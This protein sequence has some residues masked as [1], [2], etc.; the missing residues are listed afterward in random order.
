MRQLLDLERRKFLERS[1]PTSVERIVRLTELGRLHALGGRDP[2]ACWARPWDRRWR[3][4][5]FDVPTTRNSARSRLRR[6][7]R[8]RHF[9]YLQ[10]SVWISPDPLTEEREILADAS[11]DVES[12]I[13]M[14][15]HPCAGEFD[16]QI[17]AGDW[18][19]VRINREYNWTRP[20]AVGSPKASPHWCGSRPA[21]AIPPRSYRAP[22][23]PDHP[24]GSANW[25]FRNRRA[26]SA[27]AAPSS[28]TPCRRGQSTTTQKIPRKTPLARHRPL[29]LAPPDY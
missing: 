12:L 28:I 11:T 1:P 15:A 6:Y 25:H 21:N 26:T 19:F 3:L 8:N 4:V 10:N 7:L 14:E 22:E 20:L 13:F 16:T 23:S 29:A 17:A 9:G 27:W 5:I 2:L 24:R 18:D